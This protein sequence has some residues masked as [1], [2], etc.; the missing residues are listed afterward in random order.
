MRRTLVAHLLAGIA[1]ADRSDERRIE[2]GAQL[3]E[4]LYRGFGRRSR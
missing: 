3:F 1:I 4:D 2:R